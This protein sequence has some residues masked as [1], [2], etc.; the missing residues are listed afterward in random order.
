MLMELEYVELSCSGWFVILKHDAPHTLL[1]FGGLPTVYLRPLYFVR[2]HCPC[3]LY[4]MRFSLVLRLGL[5]FRL[6][7]GATLRSRL[8]LA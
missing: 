5:G 3:V 4:S 6:G 2:E 7:L 8:G 1:R